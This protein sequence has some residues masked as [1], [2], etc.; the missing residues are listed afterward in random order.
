MKLPAGKPLHFHGTKP[1]RTSEIPRKLHV[2]TGVKFIQ[3]NVIIHTHLKPGPAGDKD[4]VE[5][6]HKRLN[7]SV[8]P[9]S[10]PGPTPPL[11]SD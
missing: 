6:L 8:A 4:E 2:I 1:G 9:S 7:V 10:I 11:F 5:Q 3:Q